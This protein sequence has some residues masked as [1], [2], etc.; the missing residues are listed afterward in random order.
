MKISERK[1]RLRF[2]LIIIF[3]ELMIY[4]IKYFFRLEVLII[5]KPFPN[6]PIT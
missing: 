6:T 1:K 4:L 5:S 2:Y 3:F